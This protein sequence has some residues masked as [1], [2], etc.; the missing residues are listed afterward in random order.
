MSE[1]RF[2]LVGAGNI[3]GVHAEALIAAGAA[4]AAVVEVDQVRL[5]EFGEKYGIAAR[6]TSLEAA[7]DGEPGATAVVLA[8][9]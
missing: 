6:Y 7:L 3:G 1:P 5:D 9:P 4:P 8:T 2:V